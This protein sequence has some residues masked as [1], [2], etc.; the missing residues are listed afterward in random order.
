MATKSL[1][2]RLLLAVGIAIIL[3]AAGW[4]GYRTWPRTISF[5]PAPCLP[6]ISLEGQHW[7]VKNRIGAL[8]GEVADFR[9]ELLACLYFEYL[10]SHLGL[11]NSQILL[12][13]QGRDRRPHYRIYLVVDPNMLAAVP[14]LA[15]LRAEG[16]IPHF[17]LDTIRGQNL[18]YMRLQTAVLTGAYHPMDPPQLASLDPAQL[19][20]PLTQFLMFK[21]ATDI[22]IRKQIP[23]VPTM[24]SENQARRL[25]TDILA[26]AR[27]YKLP[28]EVFLGIGAMENDYMNVRGDLQHAVWK[29]H[30]QR[31]DII[32]KWRRGRVMV[33]DYSMGVWQITRE[34]LRYAHHLYL[35][36]KR[37]Y[38]LLPPRLRPAKKLNFDL[39]NSEVLTTYA[40][41]LLRHLLDKTHGDITKAVGAYNGSLRRPS[42]RYAAGVEAVALYARSFLERAASL[43]GMN[44]AK[45]WLLTGPPRPADEEIANNRPAATAPTLHHAPGLIHP[46][47]IS[48]IKEQQP[49][50]KQSVQK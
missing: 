2:L 35:H 48:P 41:L 4:I 29:R 38:S 27:F 33:S 40:G 8:V 19:L 50:K 22:R 44:V 13:A 43:D 17:R 24:L 37:N 18:A 39:D 6:T 49:E 34:T 26:V 28:L 10:K 1:Y 21:S 14:Y 23:P 7:V 46:L 25:A 20:G 11:D 5:S 9:S 45:A 15:R 3:S 12:T 42:Y 36:D 32:L 31:G 16:Y 47:P 30:P